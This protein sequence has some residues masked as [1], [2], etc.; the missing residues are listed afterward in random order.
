[1]KL[2][3]HKR[4]WYDKVLRAIKVT[5]AGPS[6]A[7]LLNAPVLTRWHPALSPRGHVILWGE[8]INHPRLGSAYIT[9]S[10]LI[11]INYQS[12]WAR[13]ASRWY[14]LSDSL[15]KLEANGGQAIEKQMAGSF[16]YPL[17]GFT[18]IDDPTLLQ[19]LLAAYIA[20]VHQIDAEDRAYR[21]EEG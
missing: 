11:A 4:A 5:Q 13:T 14:Q 6:A 18:N 16:H 10:Q 12:G 15:A 3:P 9:T 21:D 17:P 20:R 2:P 19:D 7:D 1:M 8:V